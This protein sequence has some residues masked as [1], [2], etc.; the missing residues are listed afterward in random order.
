MI[1]SGLNVAHGYGK[2]RAEDK[3]KMEGYSLA[4]NA[5]T[6]GILSSYTAKGVQLLAKKIDNG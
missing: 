3:A 1:A 5:T 4:T 6:S 2:P